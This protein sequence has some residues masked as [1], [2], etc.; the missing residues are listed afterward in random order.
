V[1]FLFA[2]NIGKTRYFKRRKYQQQQHMPKVRWVVSYWFRSE[3]HTLS[4]S[5]RIL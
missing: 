5:T 3:F 2:I 1:K 4:S